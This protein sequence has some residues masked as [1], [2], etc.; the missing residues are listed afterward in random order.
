MHELT[1]ITLHQDVLIEHGSLR[2]VVWDQ[3]SHCWDAELAALIDDAR[4]ALQAHSTHAERD[5]WWWA[6]GPE[7]DPTAAGEWDTQR[8]FVRWVLEE[9]EA[10]AA[11][12]EA[13]A[14]GSPAPPA[15]RPLGSH[16]TSGALVVPEGAPREGERFVPLLTHRGVVIEEILSSDTPSTEEQVQD[17]DE[18]VVL[19]DGMAVLEVDGARL[20]LVPGEHLAIP[21]GTPHRVLTTAQGTRWLAVHI[22]G[23]DAEPR[24]G[25][26]PRMH[27]RT[28]VVKMGG[29]ALTGSRT[30]GAVPGQRQDG[31]SGD[32]MP[33]IVLVLSGVLEAVWATALGRSEGLTRL[34]PSVV[35]IVG[36]TLSMA[37]LAYA[38]RTLPVGTSYAIWVGIGAALTVAYGMAT[39]TETV[40]LIKV[41]LLLGIV[42]CVVGLKAVH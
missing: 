3:I 9:A 25:R 30:S 18:W 19:L 34:T 1:G 10:E 15:D 8:T 35:F 26:R 11:R 42:G 5:A 24:R 13:G 21:A 22:H 38:M 41:L 2:A 40:S 6:Q 7:I 12:R 33:W 29:R 14:S 16:G 4:S 37:G 32:A 28:V 36:L 20:S 17:H 31:A 23:E 39:G 27:V